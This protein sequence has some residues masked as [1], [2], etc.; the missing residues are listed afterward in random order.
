[1]DTLGSTLINDI[2]DTKYTTNVIEIK[3]DKR[4]MFVMES[5]KEIPTDE[6]DI[7]TSNFNKTM[8]YYGLNDSFGI[9]IAPGTKVK[10][11]EMD[12][13]V[14][15]NENGHDEQCSSGNGIGTACDCWRSKEPAATNVKIEEEAGEEHG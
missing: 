12:K 13:A 9:Y 6:R 3:P 10:I 5:E 7:I 8:E 14:E 4:Y 11:V 1:M 2:M 15:A